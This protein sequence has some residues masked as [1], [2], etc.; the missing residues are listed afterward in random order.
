MGPERS[1]VMYTADPDR[2]AARAAPAGPAAGDHAR[3]GGTARRPSLTSIQALRGIA[4]VAVLVA[5]GLEHGDI[6]SRGILFT[7]R[8]GVE[9]FF[10]ISGFVIML[11]AGDGR[12]DLGR[13]AFRR[14][15]RVAPLYWATTILVAMLALVLPSIFRTTVFDAGYFVKSL[16]F[17][18][19]TVPG[20]TD[21]RPL[22]KLGWTLNYEMFF[23]ALTA[24]LFWC[25][26][27]WLRSTLL[28]VMMT[29]LVAL[30]FVI[31]PRASVLAYYANLN[32]LPFMAGVVLCELFRRYPDGIAR[33][34]RWWPV[35]LAAAVA[36]IAWAL[37]YSHIDYRT[38][39]GHLAITV[40]AV[41]VA[42]AAL[43]LEAQFSRH[44]RFWGWLGDISYS[45][46]LLHMFVV[47]AGW[48]VLRR[49]PLGDS[50][51]GIGLGIAAMIVVTLI[52]SSISFRWFERPLNRLAQRLTARPAAAAPRPDAAP[53]FS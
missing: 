15:F 48:A 47:G 21:W 27:A 10:V 16:A 53:R 5:H 20:T 34:A 24:L 31:P 8:F 42:V 46:Y 14:F 44:G 52:L 40:A 49:T 32:L 17:V 35:G 29:L 38:W 19:A 41:A 45:L 37:Q 7:G 12:F 22:F 25:R 26:T 13:F 43:S 39:Q 28:L 11:A 1:F 6:E 36:G 23:Y 51:V 30:S 4:A 2:S 3:P 9:V 50:A 33:L 18:P